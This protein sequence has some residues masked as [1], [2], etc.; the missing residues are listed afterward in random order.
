MVQ[1]F[2]ALDQRLRSRRGLTT[3]LLLAVLLLAIAVP[4]ALLVDDESDTKAAATPPTT[5]RTTSTT[6][7]RPTSTTSVPSTTTLG[8]SGTA[9]TAGRA[10]TTTAPPVTDPPASTTTTTQAATRCGPD[11][12]RVETVTDKESYR[13][14][15]EVK[16]RSTV[17]NTS[18][19]PC[20][21]ASYTFLWHVE[22]EAGTSVEPQSVTHADFIQEP[23]RP[24][25]R[26]VTTPTWDPLLCAPSGAC[27]RATA[28]TYTVVASWNISSPPPGPSNATFRIEA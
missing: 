18:S 8:G 1:R 24:G 4:A 17:T 28:G 14:D 9:T 7:G 20:E 15:E 11:A 3:G 26:Y 10:A 16:I 27:T 22:N 13:R 6:S 5:R 25:Q 12:F 21:I 23:L 19:A 2:R